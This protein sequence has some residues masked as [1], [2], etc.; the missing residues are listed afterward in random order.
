[1]PRVP[2]AELHAHGTGVDVQLVMHDDQVLSI[3]AVRVISCFTG[4]PDVFM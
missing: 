3:H 1:M 2:A 4:P